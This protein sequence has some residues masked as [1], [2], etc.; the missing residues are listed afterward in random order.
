[1]NYT[2]TTY[3]N[4]T[5]KVDIFNAGA[6]VKR[7]L[8]DSKITNGL[9]TVFLPVPTGGVKLME[10]D[11]AIHQAFSNLLSSFVEE[12]S[13]PRP[14]RRSGTGSLEVHLRAALLSQQVCVPIKDGKLLTGAWQEFIVFDFD[15]KAGRREVCIH[16]TGEGD[17]KEAK[18]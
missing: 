18:K 8:R 16:I 2:L 3:F 11:A 7:A 4:S 6:D 1:M 10:N 9:L 17:E 15:D 5:P 13:D 14:V 12:S